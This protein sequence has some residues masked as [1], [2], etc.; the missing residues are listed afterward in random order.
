MRCATEFAVHLV[1][2]ARGSDEVGLGYFTQSQISWRR[3]NLKEFNVYVLILSKYNPDMNGNV[4]ALKY[5]NIIK[6][7]LF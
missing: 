2:R 1:I 6:G 7:H 5:T 4:V 3:Q